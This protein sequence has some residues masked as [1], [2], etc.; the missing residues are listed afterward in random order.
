MGQS[1]GAALAHDVAIT[2][3]MKGKLFNVIPLSGSAVS[4][5][6]YWNHTQSLRNARE[7]ASAAHCNFADTG[8]LVECLRQ[9][10]P[11]E[12]TVLRLHGNDTWRPVV[13]SQYFPGTAEELVK[14]NHDFNLFISSVPDDG[15]EYIFSQT[16]DHDDKEARF[17]QFIRELTVPR[18]DTYG[19]MPFLEE[20]FF[21]AFYPYDNLEAF[22]FN[23]YADWQ[24]VSRYIETDVSFENGAF[25]GAK[26]H[27]E[28]G[29]TAY[30]YGLNGPSSEAESS[31][32]TPAWLRFV[33]SEDL[34]SWLKIN[35][36]FS[37]LVEA[38]KI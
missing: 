25:K 14:E 33:H 26:L 3:Q 9:L 23:A 29:G 12:L 21:H 37:N 1:S 24:N 6:G 28:A 16:W 5:W 8:E 4:Y 34:G 15:Y 2:P 19:K 13:E 36:F 7:L 30:Y 27:V 11:E 17:R 35:K 18:D 10:P 22:N 20:V 38:I 32:E 31:S